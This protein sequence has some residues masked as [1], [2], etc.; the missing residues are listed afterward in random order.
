MKMY[1][2]ITKWDDNTTP[3]HTYILTDDKSKMVG[4]IKVGEKVPKMFSKPM[5]FDTRYRKFECLGEFKE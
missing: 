2:E 1:K 5:G 3:N 4:Y